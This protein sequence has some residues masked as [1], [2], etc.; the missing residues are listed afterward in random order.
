MLVI[1]LDVNCR[2][3]GEKDEGGEQVGR[4][5]EKTCCTILVTVV[6]MLILIALEVW[7]G[8]GLL[9][10]IKA[11]ET[12]NINGKLI[13]M[14]IENILNPQVVPGDKDMTFDQ[15]SKIWILQSN[16]RR[17]VLI[18]DDSF[19]ASELTWSP[20]GRQLAFIGCRRNNT[21]GIWIAKQ[22]GT[23]Q[24]FLTGSN[25]PLHIFYKNPKWSPDGS[26]IAFTKEVIKDYPVH[27]HYTASLTIWIIKPDGTNLRMVTNGS[28][29]TWSPDGQRLAFELRPDPSTAADSVIWT[30]D[31]NGTNLKRVTEGTEP[32]W[33]P[34][35]RWIAYVSNTL[36]TTMFE[37]DSQNKLGYSIRWDARE[38][39]AAN[40]ITEKVTQ[41][42]HS[43]IDTKAVETIL[44]DMQK[45]EGLK[46]DN[47][48]ICSG[49]Y[50]D[51]TPS[52][53]PDSKGLLFTRNY[54]N[55]KGPHFVLSK[56]DLKYN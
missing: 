5:Y 42:T 12:D 45:K 11:H 40:L 34:E 19:S 27:G 44:K 13:N 6:S 30:C 32:A 9:T 20:D 1:P 24:T 18:G 10:I 21:P 28:N 50:D 55:E 35:G 29:P 48:L 25:D 41:L 22:D 8:S 26:W 16:G 47:E 51:W 3:K 7:K 4:R 33:S 39:W 31:L 56:L 14:Q 36:R 15:D 2:F 54:N 43:S 53:L 38:I 37:H 17:K 52:W 23:G 46:T 49:L